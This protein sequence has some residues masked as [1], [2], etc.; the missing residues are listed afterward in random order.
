MMVPYTLMGKPL[1]EEA[2]LTESMFVESSRFMP[3]MYPL[4]VNRI[5]GIS[6]A[7][8]NKKKQL[9]RVT[10]FFKDV[11]QKHISRQHEKVST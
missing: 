3:R 10:D 4:L 7:M 6:A 5:G 2:I 9:L 1:S 8:E 11:E